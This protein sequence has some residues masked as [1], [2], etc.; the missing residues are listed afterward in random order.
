M[1]FPSNCCA[2]DDE[3]IHSID[4]KQ[5]GHDLVI[6]GSNG[7]GTTPD[8]LGSKIEVLAYMPGV[9]VNQPIGSFTI[10]P[11]HSIDDAGPDEGYSRVLDYSLLETG[12]CKPICHVR[13]SLLNQETVRER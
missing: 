10:P 11:G 9:E 1:Q 2:I 3:F 12:F 13:A 8:L 4:P 5:S 6:E 7:A